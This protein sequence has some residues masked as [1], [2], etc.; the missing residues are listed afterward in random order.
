MRL[1]IAFKKL[2]WE[3]TIQMPLPMYEILEKGLSLLC[4]ALV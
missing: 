3:E 4:S 2:F 1:G